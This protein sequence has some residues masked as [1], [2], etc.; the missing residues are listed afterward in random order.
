M[1]PYGAG[2]GLSA[3]P[4]AIPAHIFVHFFLMALGLPVQ[5]RTHALTRLWSCWFQLCHFQLTSWLPLFL[6]H[7]HGSIARKHLT[8][9]ST[10]EYTSPALSVRSMHIHLNSDQLV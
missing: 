5:V 6:A 2:S 8:A 4:V 1:E 10:D 7:L 9:G 3:V